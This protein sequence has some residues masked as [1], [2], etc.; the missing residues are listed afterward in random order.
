MRGDLFRV[1]SA[2]GATGRERQGARFAV[3][4]QSDF[5]QPSTLPR[6][7]QPSRRNTGPRRSGGLN[8][9]A[10]TAD[11]RVAYLLRSQGE[12]REKNCYV[13]ILRG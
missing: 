8:H 10:R 1:K 7:R 5:V 11:L 13:A 12:T 2:R 4:V 6:A 9:T 3:V